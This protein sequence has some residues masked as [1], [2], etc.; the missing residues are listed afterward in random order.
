MFGEVLFGDQR[1]GDA[2]VYLN[3]VGIPSAEALGASFISPVYLTGTGITS[4]EQF[5]SGR[6]NII[7]SGIGVVSQVGFGASALN[8]SALVINLTPIDSAEAFGSLRI[9]FGPGRITGTNVKVNTS[10]AAAIAQAGKINANDLP[11]SNQYTVTI[12]AVPK[13]GT[14]RPVPGLE[15]VVR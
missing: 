5:G 1:F 4:A 15:G 10:I 6:L 2:P 7:L 3:G 8:P 11:S 13:S 12:V 9:V 14:V